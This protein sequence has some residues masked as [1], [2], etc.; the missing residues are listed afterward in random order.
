MKGEAGRVYALFAAK[1][2]SNVFYGVPIKD[3]VANEKLNISED[4]KRLKEFNKLSFNSLSFAVVQIGEDP[5]STSY[6]RGKIKDCREVGLPIDHIKLPHNISAKNFKEIFSCINNAYDAIIL[7]LP[8]PPAVAGCYADLISSEKDVDGFKVD[9]CFDPATP[10]GIISFLKN[11]GY[12]IAGKTALVVGRS[13]CVG[14]P[15]CKMLTD[16]NATTICAHSY[17]PKDK[18]H[19]LITQSDIVFTAIDKTEY[20]DK[21]LFKKSDCDVI[22]I[23][24]GT[25]IIGKLRGNLTEDAI[26]LIKSNG[27]EVISGVGGVGLLTRLALIENVYD[28]FSK[29]LIADS[30]DNK[31]KN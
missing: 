11:T 6:I 15:L 5:S 28:A 22:D 31:L 19:K 17:T 14:A 24:L 27:R 26:D 18:L 25:N 1:C 16:N 2:M 10:S 30:F 4:I 13:G 8:V 3:Y 9:S 20:L 23:G 7:Q 21:D 29:K 12:Q